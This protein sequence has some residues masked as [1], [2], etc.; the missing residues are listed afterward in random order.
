MGAFNNLF[1]DTKKT[2]GSVSRKLPSGLVQSVKLAE[3]PSSMRIDSFAEAA[4]RGATFSEKF[5]DGEVTFSRSRKD[6]VGSQAR[7]ATLDLMG[8]TPPTDA[9]AVPESVGTNGF[10]KV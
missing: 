4:T 10:A 3:G 9:D 8:F 2:T 7:N 5:K 1:T 6:V